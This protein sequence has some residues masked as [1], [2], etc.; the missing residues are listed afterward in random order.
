MN[1][2]LKKE[3]KDEEGKSMWLIFFLSF[4][5]G[6]AALL[7][8]CVFPMIPMTVSFLYKQSKS[9]AAGIRNAIIYGIINY[10]NL[11][12]SGNNCDKCFWLRCIKCTYQQMSHSI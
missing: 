10:S 1:K 3:K 4:L 2:V 11:C 6:F 9:K 7:T 12:D 8:P 5:S